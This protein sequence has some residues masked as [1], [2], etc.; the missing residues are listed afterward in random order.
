MLE[1][2]QKR[3]F[4]DNNLD[5]R[6]NMI[7]GLANSPGWAWYTKKGSMAHIPTENVWLLANKD[8]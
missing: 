7:P 3:S 2:L 8:V 4:V 1:S 6:K 5:N